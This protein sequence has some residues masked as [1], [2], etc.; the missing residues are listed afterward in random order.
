MKDGV[1][2][3]IL[4]KGDQMPEKIGFVGLGIMGGPMARNLMRAGYELVLY[5]RTRSKAEELAAEVGAKVA[6]IPK[7]VAR[8][9]G[10]IFTML[11]GPPEV[12]EVVAGED[13]LLEGAGE[14]S[15]IIDMSTSSPVLARELARI[16]RERGVG[17]LDAPVSGGDV[18]AEEGTLSTMVGGDKEDFERARPLFEVMGGTVTHVGPSGAGQLVKATNQ[19]VVALVIEAVSE[20][21]VLGSR[22]GVA[23]EMI[24]EVLSGGL[25]ANKVM[26]VKREKFLNHDFEPGGKVEFHRKDLRIA[27]EAGREYGVPLPVTAVVCQM[28]EALMAKGRGGWDH[29]SLLTVIE[30]L[31]QCRVASPPEKR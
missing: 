3:E 24:L 16:A 14:G 21:L 10:V 19:I 18:G 9:S 4:A 7:E 13:G 31:A 2:D 5:N 6:E 28:F 8:S 23:P 12:E 30:D 26:E 15:L 1:G 20:A 17:M 29:S 25:A 22:G 11:P 27:M